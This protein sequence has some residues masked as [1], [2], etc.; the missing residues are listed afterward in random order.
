MNILAICPG[1]GTQ[2]PQSN[3]YCSG[4]RSTLERGARVSE[5]EAR[6]ILAAL[7]RRGL[8]SRLRKRA[9]QAILAVLVVAWVSSIAYDIWNHP[10]QPTTQIGAEAAPGDWPMFQRDLRHTGFVPN[11]TFRPRGETQWVYESDRA[12]VAS[13]VVVEQVVYLTTR[14]PND[15]K[16]V[17][18]DADTGRRLW[19]RPA[20]APV[21]RSMSVAGG[22][23]FVTMRNG[24]VLALNSSDG[25]VKWE[26]DAD[27]PLFT[28]PTVHRGFVYV[29]TFDKRLLLLDA[30]TGE[31]L[32]DR[33]VGFRVTSD[34]V[35]NDHVVAFRAQDN[36]VYILDALT[37]RQ[38]MYY[39]TRHIAGSLA[40]SGDSLY[41]ADIK[42]GLRALD[43]TK[44]L[45]PLETAMRTVRVNLFVWGLGGFPGLK[46]NV[47][48]RT[49][50]GHSFLGTP[51]VGDGMVYA[52]SRSG[53]VF[54]M[55][56]FDGEPVWSYDM[57]AEPSKTVAVTAEYLFVGAA[58]GKL[59]AI[60]V[61]TGEPE[62][63]LQLDGAI[64]AGPVIAN[65]TLYV[66]T[67][68]GKL[69]A[70]R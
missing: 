19:E 24:T 35:V 6:R 20:S 59:H 16:I 44:V 64:S 47:W 2:N 22:L 63:E 21:D 40:L 8:G 68:A 70:I 3:V 9:L 31:V 34:P 61:G 50:Q 25:T 23:V 1:C 33:Y 12:I 52:A 55:G 62:L 39:G 32:W 56:E 46:G 18:L 42:G 14:A 27:V 41:T 30:A 53:N 29:G 49:R 38:K 67:L 36:R 7:A 58:D 15:H 26:L 69:Y 57:G 17:A 5:K 10:D 51:A 43:W 45:Y 28:T 66:A 37:G 54:K 60:D 11:S 4:C 13:P 48:G 65:D